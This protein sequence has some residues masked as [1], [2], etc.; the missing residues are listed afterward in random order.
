MTAMR[1]E[2]AVFAAFFAFYLLGLALDISI[3]LTLAQ[4]SNCATEI[5]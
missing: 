3:S 2:L 5:A 4:P 1:I